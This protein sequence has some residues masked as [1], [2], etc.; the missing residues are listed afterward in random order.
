MHTVFLVWEHFCLVSR[1]MAET[2]EK[3]L[4]AATWAAVGSAEPPIPGADQV[5]ACT[6]AA[7]LWAPVWDLGTGW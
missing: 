2:Q 1:P 7:G 6:A 5:E 3:E 4:R